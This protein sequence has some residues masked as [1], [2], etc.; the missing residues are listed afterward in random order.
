MP[1]LNIHNNHI[2]YSRR[3]LKSI[4]KKRISFAA[5]LRE[6]VWGKRLLDMKRKRGDG[7]GDQ[8]ENMLPISQVPRNANASPELTSSSVPLRSIF[9]RV[10]HQIGSSPLSKSSSPLN[11]PHHESTNTEQTPTYKP[12]RLFGKIKI[13]SSTLLSNYV[14]KLSD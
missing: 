7:N 11:Q 3:S 8:R 2:L 9:S 6:L 14:G 1:Y 13:T 4:I 12:V 10:F 5:A